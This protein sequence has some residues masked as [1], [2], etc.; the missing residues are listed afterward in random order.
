MSAGLGF[1]NNTLQTPDLND[2]PEQTVRQVIPAQPEVSVIQRVQ[3]QTTPNI[4]GA[5]RGETRTEN[6]KIV[7]RPAIPEQVIE[8]KIPG[9]DFPERNE[10]FVSRVDGRVDAQWINSRGFFTLDGRAG[11]EYYWD[12]DTSPLE[13]NGSLGS[14]YV[15]RL[16]SKT[17]FSGNLVLAYLSQPDYSQVNVV[18]TPGSSGNYFTGNLKLDLS[19]RWK[20]RFSTVTSITGNSILYEE[21]T[22]SNYWQAGV[23]NEFRWLQS[24]RITWVAETRY[25]VDQYLEGAQQAF[26]TAFLLLGADWTL[27]RRIRSTIRLGETV[28]T[29]D[30]GSSRSS[31]YG[32]LGLA[33]QPTRRDQV[34]LTAR[35]GF[36]QTSSANEENVVTRC[37]ASYTRTF[38]PRLLGSLAGN[39]VHNQTTSVGGTEA[40]GDVIDG[41]LL[42]QYTFTRRFS[43]NARYSYT[44]STS[45]SGF[46]DFDRS[47]IFLTGEYEF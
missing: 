33:Y 5:F 18:A 8:T 43:I 23:G 36:E 12:R 19:Y 10:S 2:V 40:T 25:T 13:F 20:P 44:L 45:S 15:R 4:G 22:T 21:R 42:F 16:G 27:S 28:R 31:P 34:S 3:V 30:S 24:P 37:S 11:T 41:S 47:R 32:E 7:L 35:Y 26:S 9:I 14:T 38:S 46:N 1:D 6:R 29:F 17:Q 39:Y